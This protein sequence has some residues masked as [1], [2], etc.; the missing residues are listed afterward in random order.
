MKHTITVILVLLAALVAGCGLTS[1][2]GSGNV[3]TQ[4]E[5]ITGF[6]EVEISQGF[7]VD[8]SQGDTFSVVV[9]VD[10]NLVQ[11]LQVV[12]QG[13]TLKIGM[14]P[15][16]T[17]VGSTLRAE[18]TMPEL[19]RLT[20]RHGSRATVSGSG[21]DVTVEAFDGSRG[22]LSAFAVENATVVARGGSRLTVNVSGTL[23]AD[24]HE[25]SRVDYLGNPT[26]VT[27]NATGGSSV[28]PQ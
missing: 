12:K 18:V 27:T 1:T 13:S 17:Y 26:H 25:G 6:D 9:H 22:D 2:T 11:Y 4:E 3:V 7:R 24:A 21:G 19:S 28:E 8:I 16:R 20:V 5:T 10:D 14:E 23:V 15:D